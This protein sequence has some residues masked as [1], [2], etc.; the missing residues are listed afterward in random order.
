M[1]Y[2]SLLLKKPVPRIYP[3]RLFVARS[4]EK[5][6]GKD[7][8]VKKLAVMPAV[9]RRGLFTPRAQPMDFAAGRSRMCLP[10]EVLGGV[11]SGPAAAA[12]ACRPEGR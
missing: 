7:A 10:G 3:G 8:G 9:V 6:M 12:T 5:A 2:Y 4:S 11:S 1:I